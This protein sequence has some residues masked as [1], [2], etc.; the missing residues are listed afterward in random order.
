MPNHAN[1]FKDENGSRCKESNTGDGKLSLAGL[2]GDIN[3][4]AWT[5][6]GTNTARPECARD[7]E[8]KEVPACTKFGTSIA[9]PN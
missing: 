3:A 4:L 2:L 1:D 9:N 7:L 5:G 8:D 6:S